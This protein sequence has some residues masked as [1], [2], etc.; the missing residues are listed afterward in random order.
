MYTG[1]SAWGV[2]A[3][4]LHVVQ[5]TLEKPYLFEK[6]LGIQDVQLYLTSQA[7]S[8]AHT[9]KQRSSTK[10]EPIARFCVC[11]AA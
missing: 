8:S 6:P 10:T 4:K 11:E 7:N 9:E 1:K 2:T 3:I 5:Q